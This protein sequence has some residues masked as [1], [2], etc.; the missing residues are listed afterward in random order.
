[1]NMQN[2]W[3]WYVCEDAMYVVMSWRVCG[4]SM[5]VVA[6]NIYVKID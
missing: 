5:Y 3:W 1:M 4:D 2:M 6:G